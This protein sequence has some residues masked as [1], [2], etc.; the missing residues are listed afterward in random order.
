MKI[1]TFCQHNFAKNIIGT[2][3]LYCHTPPHT[4]IHTDCNV[5]RLDNFPLITFILKISLF[6]KSLLEKTHSG[7]LNAKRLNGDSSY[8]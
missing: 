8:C 1:M 2:C 4:H 3:E 6:L 7:T 5:I